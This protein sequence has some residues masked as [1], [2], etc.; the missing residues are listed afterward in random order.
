[1][2]LKSLSYREFPEIHPRYWELEEFELGQVNLFVGNNASGKSRTLSVI[3]GLSTLLQSPTLS[4][5]QGTFDV[6]FLKDKSEISFYLDIQNGIIKAER[7][8]IDNDLKFSRDENG[9]GKIFNANL[10]LSHEFSIPN[11][12]VLATRRDAVQ[13]PYLE[14]LFE[15]ST[16][17]R[18]FR[19]SKEEEKQ[20]LVL[21]DSN[22]SMTDSHNQNVTNQA[23]EIF[24]K[25]T[26]KFREEF[27]NK[28]LSDFN[29][30]GYNVFKIDVGRLQS[31]KIDSPIGNKLIG[32][33]VHEMDRPG[34]TDQ[35]EM[36]DGMFRALS[37]IT[38]FNYYQLTNKDLTVL[39]DDIGEGLDYE[40]ST[41]LIRLAIEKSLASNIQLI[42]SSNDKFVMNNTNLKYWQVVVRKGPKVKLYNHCNSREKFEEFKFSGLNNFDFFVTESFKNI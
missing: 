17:V 14:D 11:N 32:L 15:W 1:M 28:V 29:S 26:S 36:S 2:I 19:F 22:K 5:T 6:K 41:N 30:I 35:N 21:I 4:I 8:K 9:K 42:M 40:R 31:V 27:I 13:Y 20:T 3:Y 38:H 37:L 18:H 12:Q 7:L 10:N 24:R 34:F 16:N 39:V 33:R 23:V 25:G